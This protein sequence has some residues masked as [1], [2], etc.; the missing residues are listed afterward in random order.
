MSLINVFKKRLF[1]NLEQKEHSQNIKW[2][3]IASN[4]NVNAIF[5]K[6]A[7]NGW[8]NWFQAKS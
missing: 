5:A 8:K 2:K 6:I 7:F 3:S 4:S 1:R